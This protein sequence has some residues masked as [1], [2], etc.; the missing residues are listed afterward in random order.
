[1]AATWCIFYGMAIIRK[2]IEKTFQL[3]VTIKVEW[4]IKFISSIPVEWEEKKN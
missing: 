3:D 2:L 4:K 1:M